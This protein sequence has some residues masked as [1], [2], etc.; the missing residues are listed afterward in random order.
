V[1]LFL[2]DNFEISI[3]KG[4]FH[5]KSLVEYL[6]S[7]DNEPVACVKVYTENVTRLHMLDQRSSRHTWTEVS[8]CVS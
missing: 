5:C 8:I 3:N 7:P 1:K 6:E 4:E 2:G